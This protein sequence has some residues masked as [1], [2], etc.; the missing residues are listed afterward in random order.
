MVLVKTVVVECKKGAGKLVS[1]HS[2]H[3][4]VTKGMRVLMPLLK[5]VEQVCYVRPRLMSVLL[6][7]RFC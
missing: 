4:D 5:V 1:F 2:K 3:R 6:L 7:A